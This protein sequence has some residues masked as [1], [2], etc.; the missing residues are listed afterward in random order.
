MTDL[1]LTNIRTCAGMKP[2]DTAGPAGPDR[3]RA[4]SRNHVYIVIRCYAVLKILRF[5]RAF[6]VGSVFAR[7]YS[8]G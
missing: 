7:E 8:V 5:L 6:S 3:V 1:I 2:C 4:Y